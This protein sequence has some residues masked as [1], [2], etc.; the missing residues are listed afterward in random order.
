[1][2]QEW[3]DS[4]NELNVEPPINEKSVE[5]SHKMKIEERTCMSV[6]LGLCDLNFNL[7]PQYISY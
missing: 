3:P 2:G 4:Y 7:P 5:T 1:M 6:V